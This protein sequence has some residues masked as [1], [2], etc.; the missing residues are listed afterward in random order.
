M[1]GKTDVAQTIVVVAAPRRPQKCRDRSCQRLNRQSRRIPERRR[2]RHH[3]RRCPGRLRSDPPER[4]PTSLPALGWPRID[5]P[6]PH[7]AFVVGAAVEGTGVGSGAAGAPVVVGG[8]VGDGAVGKGL[9]DRSS[10]ST[11]RQR[12]WVTRKTTSQ[13]GCCC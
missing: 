10:C 13:R 12:S 6:D 2:L 11:S 4:H 7:R 3:H 8:G 5:I 9:A 1:R